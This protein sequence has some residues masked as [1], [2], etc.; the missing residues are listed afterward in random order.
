MS[1]GDLFD[2]TTESV[3]AAGEHPPVGRYRLD[4]GT[5]RWAWSAEIYTMY[6]FEPGEVVPTAQLM[7]SHA[8]P[9]DLARVDAVLRHAAETGEPFSAVHRVYD[10]RRRLHLVAVTGQTRRVPDGGGATEVAGYF[11]DMTDVHRHLAQQEASRAIQASAERRGA[12]EQAKGVLMVV[13][14]IGADEAFDRLRL[15]SNR[16]NVPVR[17]LAERLLER[18]TGPARPVAPTAAALG[19]FLGEAREP[20][21]GEPA[22]SGHG[23]GGRSSGPPPG[24]PL[25]PVTPR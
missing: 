1:E 15:A 9:E 5:G 13:H 23:P 11:I 24:G 14:G 22:P 2:D 21:A 20:R 19:E 10:A 18:F 4:L 8:H 25:A 16:L 12:I 7:L 17:D 6:G 3:L